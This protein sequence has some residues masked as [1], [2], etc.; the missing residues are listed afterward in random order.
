M[1]PCTSSHANWDPHPKLL[2]YQTN[3]IAFSCL[4]PA[5][6]TTYRLLMSS[7]L[8][9]RAPPTPLNNPVGWAT[10]SLPW[11]SSPG[12]WR[13]HSNLVPPTPAPSLPS[14]CL[15]PPNL[16]SEPCLLQEPFLSSQHPPFIPLF[17]VPI[18]QLLLPF[19]HAP[20]LPACALRSTCVQLI[21]SSGFLSSCLYHVPGLPNPPSQGFSVSEAHCLRDYC[22]PH[23]KSLASHPGPSLL[24]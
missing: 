2:H 12:T 8:R 14:G 4:F 3:T 17:H 18:Q 11:I 19:L 16:Q 23:P 15:N 6:P 5:S 13:R 1:K 9:T 24:R 10:H 7:K 22:V 20:R 21:C